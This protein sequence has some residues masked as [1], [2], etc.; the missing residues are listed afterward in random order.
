M[1]S[2]KTAKRTND[3]QAKSS[4]SKRAKVTPV[5]K[6]STTIMKA[7]TN[8]ETIVP[9][10][11]SCRSM[12][13]AAA[14]AAL[15]TPKDARHED[16]DAVLRMLMDVFGAEKSRWE[17]RIATANG[18]SEQA[19]VERT[20]KVN[21]KDV[22]DTELKTQKGVVKERMED[23]SKATEMVEECKQE[24]SAALTRRE[25]AQ[26]EHGKL[27]ETQDHHLVL[28]E[29]I[30]GLKE[31]VYENP[32][33]MKKHIAD[34]SAVLK[35]L[36]AEEALVKTLPQ[37]FNR[38]PSERGGFDEIALQQLD[39]QMDNHLSSLNSKIEAADAIVTE[40]EIAVTAWGA[41]V[42]VAEE[43]KRESEEA[44]QLAQTHQEQLQENLNRARKVLKE[45][46]AV[47][48]SK[49]A[50][51]ASEEC[52]L[53]A[54]EE[55]LGALEFLNEYVIPPPEE[56]ATTSEEVVAESA[57]NPTEMP[58]EKFV[59][60]QEM[61]IPTSKSKEI[62]AKTDFEDVPSPTKHARRSLGADVH[63]VVA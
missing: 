42:E 2:A 56:K 55:V 16:Q 24:L 44:L 63:M 47:V 8:A 40:H 19:T 57:A 22:A 49:E 31:G 50:N 52:G 13:V 59:D 62:E 53:Y 23:V 17:A 7:L 14:N 15:Q 12:L 6:A 20:E 51:V 27:V 29:T 48:K 33:D 34:V 58:M 9:G 54:V 35:D 21:E 45:Y 10:P 18:A 32:K 5:E 3:S 43:K 46:T 60:G 36:G 61:I 11:E 4:A 25:G 41:A 39:S 28:Q 37:I 38:K 1:P 26:V 30:K